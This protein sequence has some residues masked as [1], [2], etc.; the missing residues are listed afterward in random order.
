MGIRAT[1]GVGLLLVAVGACTPPVKPGGYVVQR[2]DP[3]EDLPSALVDAA[4][5]LQL[6]TKAQQTAVLGDGEGWPS[7][8]LKRRYEDAAADFAA[9]GGLAEARAHADQAALYRQAAMVAAW[10]TINTYAEKPHDGYPI[11]IAHLLAVSYALLGDLPDARAQS[12]RLDAYPN[13]PTTPWHAPW[14][15]WLAQVDPVWPPDLDALPLGLPAPT[16]GVSPVIPFPNYTLVEPGGARFDMADPSTLI[17]LALWHDR[18]AH[19]LAG[20]D[21]DAVDTYLARYHFPVEPDV[22]GVPLPLLFLVGSD[23][24][25]PDD[26]PFLADLTGAGGPA[27]IHTWADR[28]LLAAMADRSRRADGTFS[29][30]LASDR[31]TDLREQLVAASREINGSTLGIHRTLA[32]VA[33]AGAMRSLAFVPEIEVRRRS[34]ESGKLRIIAL[35]LGDE[36][37]A[38]ASPEGR[39]SLAA[40]DAGNGYTL[41]ASETLHNAIRRYP[42]L[43]AARYALDALALHNDLEREAPGPTP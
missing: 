19:D 22:D 4:W 35:D 6:A 16:P 12:A 40:W 32:D 23:L 43:E 27:A 7:L 18:V 24:L 10:S 9:T 1:F 26:G 33:K 34:E 11:G 37:A 5:P 28:S 2:P 13:D 20:A 38:S 3:G 17:A 29:G 8:I 21:G 14:K 39:M 42:S 30:E 15:A 31:A 25:V 36:E 41:R